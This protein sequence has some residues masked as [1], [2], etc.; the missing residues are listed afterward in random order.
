MQNISLLGTT[1]KKMRQDLGL[2]QDD[3][4]DKAGISYSTLAKLEHGGIKSPTFKTIGAIAKALEVP[5]DMLL[6]NPSVLRPVKPEF[7]Y[8]DINGVLVN[9]WDKM[10]IKFNKLYGVETEE[11]AD[12]LWFY[13]HVIDKGEMM[14]EEF[15]T[16]LQR[17]FSLKEKPNWRQIYLQSV[18]PVK[19]IHELLANISKQYKVGILSNTFPGLINE[20]KKKNLIPDLEYSSIVDSSTVKRIKPDPQIYEVATEKAN[21]SKNKILFLD[22]LQ[23]NITAAVK[24]GWQGQ[25]ID[26]KNYKKSAAELTHQLELSS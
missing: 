11:I 19:P 16:I 9:H 4:S 6:L 22:D 18:D 3:L 8:C 2:T 14:V 13:N 25:V 10:F 15:E 23:K 1:V 26:V 24:Y 12:T 17:K 20:M 21:V 5:V 7:I